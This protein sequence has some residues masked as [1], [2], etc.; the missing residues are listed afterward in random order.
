MTKFVLCIALKIKD[1]Y[2]FVS[3][4]LPRPPGFGGGFTPK[5][6]YYILIYLCAKIG[7]FVKNAQLIS[8]SALLQ[9]VFFGMK[10]DSEWKLFIVYTIYI[11][12]VIVLAVPFYAAEKCIF[13]DQNNYNNWTQMYDHTFIDSSILCN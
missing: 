5:F 2:D 7:A 12:Y 3:R 6:I 10:V 13:S 1:Y 11:W 4:L 9:S 8:L